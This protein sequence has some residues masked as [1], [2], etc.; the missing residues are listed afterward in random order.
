MKLS[1]RLST[2]AKCV[3]KDSRVIDVGTD[4][5]YIPIYLMKNKIAKSCMATDIRKGPLEKAKLNIK[6]HGVDAIELMLTDGLNGIRKE[7]GDVIIMA[8]MGGYL[9]IEILSNNLQLA[10]EA[11]K[12]I[13]QPQQDIDRVRK[14]LHKNGF[15]IEDEE[16]VEDAGKY[17]TTIVAISGIEKYEKPY[18]YEYGKILINKKSSVFKEYMLQKQ[19]KLKK[20]YN[21]ISQIDSEYTNKRRKELDEELLMQEEVMKCIL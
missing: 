13:L 4:H 19:E 2:I 20:I 3:P 14:F 21:S 6:A 15:K 11:H 9:I 10:Q 16:F 7:D 18:E 12:L 1:N 17:Y 8:G 5:A